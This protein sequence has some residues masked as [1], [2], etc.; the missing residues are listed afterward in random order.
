MP[1]AFQFAVAG[2]IGALVREIV[3]GNGLS[4]PRVSENVFYLG[5][6]SGMIIGAF[7]GML[8]DN[9]FLTSLLSGYVGTSAIN[10]LLPRVPS[11][12]PI[13]S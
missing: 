8:V 1:L 10:H 13:P 9:N 12:P 7:V 5:F 11:D 3:R 2:S 6:M 4:L